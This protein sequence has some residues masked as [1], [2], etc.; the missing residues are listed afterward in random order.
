MDHDP[1]A[2]LTGGTIVVVDGN[3]VVLTGGQFGSGGTNYS[4]GNPFWDRLRMNGEKFRLA[5]AFGISG[6]GSFPD[7]AN[8]ADAAY[9]TGS[10]VVGAL[11]YWKMGQNGK[12]RNF[13][14]FQVTGISPSTK[15]ATVIG[16][17]FQYGTG[18]AM[19]L[20]DNPASSV[21][22]DAIV[23]SAVLSSGMAGVSGTCS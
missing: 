17:A 6:Y 10:V 5:S 13:P 9:V 12:L 1:A 15:K 2:A 14:L 18:A 8:R 3:P 22:S 4:A 7:L 11:D 23:D 20:V 19:G 16:S 21:A